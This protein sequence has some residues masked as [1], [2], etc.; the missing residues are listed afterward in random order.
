MDRKVHILDVLYIL[1][2][3]II[4]AFSLVAFTI[5]NKIV[6]G[7]LSGIATILFYVLNTPV[8]M[9]MLVCNA[10]LIILQ[11][12]MIGKKSAWKTLLSILTVSIAIEL[13]MNFFEIGPMTKDPILAGLYG[14]LLAGIGVGL[15]F[16]GGGTTGGID[17]VSQIL[18]I[19][20]RIP[21]G[22]VILLSNI[23]ITFFAGISFGP[24]LALYG[25]ITVFFS[26]KVIDSV[27]E[28]MSVFRT[29]FIMS[30]NYE[31]LGWAI[32]E[33]LH[34][35]VT[36]LNGYG[37]YSGKDSFILLTVVRRREIPM[38]RNIIY[39]IDPKAFV[40]IGD[41][42]QVLGRGFVNFDN[43]IRRVKDV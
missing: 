16:K 4:L 9:F 24:E 18:N 29:V 32:I 37:V 20:Y 11:A 1:L 13:M 19:R 5:P 39:D 6:A 10:L 17:I 23:F 36:C 2:G 25:L 15:A 12:K 7:G 31:E 41:S 38:L 14:G 26:G 8:G 42:R 35:G 27:L 30:K 28:G 3:S 22:D 40:I 21:I 34:R 43:E 33:E